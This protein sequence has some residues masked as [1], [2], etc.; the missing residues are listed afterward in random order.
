M[1]LQLYVYFTISTCLKYV[2]QSIFNIE[3][4]IM[5]TLKL[6]GKLL[7]PVP[8]ATFTFCFS[9]SPQPVLNA[10]KENQYLETHYRSTFSQSAVS[11]PRIKSD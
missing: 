1:L 7:F 4:Y 2:G 3:I 6:I 5:A 10:G 8:C 11:L 9:R